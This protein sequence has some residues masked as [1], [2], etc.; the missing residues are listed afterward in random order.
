MNTSRQINIIVLLV[1]AALITAGAYTLWDPHRATEAKDRQLEKTVDR[2]AYLF[3][4]NC[5]VCHGD[6]G[7]GGVKSN[8]LKQAP[9]LNRPDLQGRETADG[10]VDP[11]LK[12]NAY[13]RVY[14]TIQC[15]RIG[16]AMPTWGQ[17]Q[18][19]PL[20][21][22][23]IKQLATLIT[24]GTGWNQSREY[25]I[26][27]EPE[28]N[29]NGYGSAGV[30]LTDDVD[31]TT[32]TIPLTVPP[33]ANIGLVAKGMHLEFGDDPE[34]PDNQELTLVTAVDKETNTVEVQRALGT[35]AAAPH[36]AGTAI[37]F[38]PVPPDPPTINGTN[39]TP[40]CG[41]ILQ[42]TG[43]TPTPAPPSTNITISAKGIKFNTD[44]LT[45]VADQQLTIT[46]DNQETDGTI[47]NINFFNGKNSKAE[48]LGATDL[49]PGPN[50]STLIL[51][52][53]PAGQY[54]F[55]CDVH[56]QMNGL[57]T[58]L[59]PGAAA[60]ADTATPAAAETGTAAA[61]APAS[62]TTATATP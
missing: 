3:S 50:Q 7:E 41:Q 57:L 31:D 17:S 48:S 32:T 54:Y 25:A 43:P 30:T 20:N 55:Q 23:Q 33:P 1:F 18:G 27:G 9:A 2:G 49:L 34:N 40:A 62:S 26:Y 46:F 42:A 58:T 28:F 11:A 14:Y 47:H 13:K 4:Q 44:A 10:P 22:E 6:S 16:T 19:G 38:P 56:T 21:D 15:G 51:R 5:I 53:L 45:G 59:A 37:L 12:T 61:T 36:K 39:V 8:R 29:I 35:T 52:A 60:A 24:E